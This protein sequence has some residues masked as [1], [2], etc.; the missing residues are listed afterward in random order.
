MAAVFL[1]NAIS[2]RT[3]QNDLPSHLM[4]YGG[5]IG[6]H[7]GSFLQKYRQKG[8]YHGNG[9]SAVQSAIYPKRL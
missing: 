6:K 3:L 5:R 9:K 8:G 7:G 1:R 2:A 4:V